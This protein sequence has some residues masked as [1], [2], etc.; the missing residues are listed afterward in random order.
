LDNVFGSTGSNINIYDV[1]KRLES[2]KFVPDQSNEELVNKCGRSKNWN[3]K[4]QPNYFVSLPIENTN[5][6]NNL[7]KL[8]RDLLDSNQTIKN[9]LVPD[10]SYHLTLCT[11]RIDT[12]LEMNKVQNVLDK[13]FKSERAKKLL[14]IMIDFVSISE[15]YNKVL[16]VKSVINESTKKLEALKTLIL[17]E[18]EDA[19]VN[20]AGNYYEFVPHLT[21]LKLAKNN[22]SFDTETV[23]SLIKDHIW[24][25]YSDFNFGEQEI[26]EFHLCKMTNINLSKSYPI[27]YIVKIGK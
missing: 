9:Y 4:L 2:E 25:N 12:E 10:T 19:S 27:D 18:F 6:K 22:N 8:T 16:Y 21:V 20:T 24:D 5:L 17:K 11:L 7:S 3:T 15:F 1:I 26:G 13:V 23:M 14:P